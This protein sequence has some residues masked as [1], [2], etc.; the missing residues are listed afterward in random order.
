MA[1][2]VHRG[3]VSRYRRQ[4]LRT[5]LDGL[6]A[7]TVLPYAIEIAATG[8]VVGSTRF[9]KVDPLN[10][11]AE[12]GHTW[13]AASWQRSYVNTESKYLMLE[14]AFEVLRCIRIQLQTD[15]LNQ[16]SRIAILRLGAKQEGI[17]RHERIMPD[18]RRR[19]SVRYSIIEEEWAG[20]KAALGAR[21]RMG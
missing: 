20:I 3:A 18:G 9:W 1:A 21:L 11:K 4:L 7:A 10:R 5:A 19:N 13:I 2:P 12:I 6:R 16:R 17:V 15:E 8:Q 14:Y